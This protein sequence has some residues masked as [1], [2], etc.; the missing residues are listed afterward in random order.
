MLFAIAQIAEIIDK[1]EFY[2]NKNETEQ[3]EISESVSN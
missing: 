1:N 3:N 2:E